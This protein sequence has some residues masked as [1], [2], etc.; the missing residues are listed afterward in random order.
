MKIPGKYSLLKTMTNNN[1]E[2][3]EEA[4]PATKKANQEE[5]QDEKLQVCRK[6]TRTESLEQGT[7]RERLSRTRQNLITNY[8]KA[9]SISD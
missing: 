7:E 2:R 8:F 3:K 4:L 9:N 1:V 5:W 6:E